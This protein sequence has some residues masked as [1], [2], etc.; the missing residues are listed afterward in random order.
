MAGKN[1]VKQ[2]RTLELSNSVA[3]TRP[4]TEDRVENDNAPSVE[5]ISKE[6]PQT[7]ETSLQK[8][9]KIESDMDNEDVFDNNNE[10]GTEHN[11]R[12]KN[13]PKKPKRMYLD[14]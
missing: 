14:A 1:T 2:V 4:Y 11:W 3:T 9:G 7:F 13:E 10:L 12:N 5:Q 8:S 6:R